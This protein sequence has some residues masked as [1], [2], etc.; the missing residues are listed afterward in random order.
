MSPFNPAPSKTTDDLQQA[1]T[2]FR[3]PLSAMAFAKA[4]WD[5]LCEYGPKSADYLPDG[6]SQYL[7]NGGYLPGLTSELS[8]KVS[9]EYLRNVTLPPS[10]PTYTVRSTPGSVFHVTLSV[11]E[12]EEVIQACFSMFGLALG[13][14]FLLVFL[15]SILAPLFQ[16][17]LDFANGFEQENG[18]NETST[19][20][21]DST[22]KKDPAPE[23]HAREKQLTDLQD[24]LRESYTNTVEY[25]AEIRRLDGIIAQSKDKN[26]VAF[27]RLIRLRDKKKRE[28]DAAR[29]NLAS[30]RSQI[31][32]LGAV[33][34]GLEYQNSVLI[35]KA[36]AYGEEKEDLAKENDRL[37]LSVDDLRASYDLLSEYNADIEARNEDLDQENKD[38]MRRNEEIETENVNWR[39]TL[40]ALKNDSEVERMK[41][42]ITTLQGLHALVINKNT[43]LENGLEYVQGISA[44]N[45]RRAT[46]ADN[47]LRNAEARIKDLEVQLDAHKDLASERD[48]LIT[49]ALDEI[50]EQRAEMTRLQKE[51]QSLMTASSAQAVTL[52]NQTLEIVALRVEISHQESTYIRLSKVID[53]RDEEIKALRGEMSHL[54]RTL[55][56]NATQSFKKDAEINVLKTA[57]DYMLTR[58]E[59]WAEKFNA[60]A[61]YKHT[62]EEAARHP[63]WES[64]GFE[65]LVVE[66]LGGDD[67]EDL[68][69]LEDLPDTT[70]RSDSADS[71]AITEEEQGLVATLVLTESEDAGKED[72]EEIYITEDEDVVIVDDAWCPE[73]P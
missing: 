5:C 67:F 15:L 7:I 48:E 1:T 69:D 28:L 6:M 46:Q 14:I 17:S 38:L 25:R 30:S 10:L 27:Q 50:N 4:S 66:Q 54:G 35:E 34:K 72:Y 45:A 40:Q 53:S 37:Q 23:D 29:A 8:R 16:L 47:N 24:L 56:D 42:Q 60:F 32:R 59:S 70:E 26:S 61:W 68:E 20:K 52:S 64:E 49:N 65:E 19:L 31:D 73:D 2:M 39:A 41:K 22:P 55:A 36:K 3:E 33:I 9:A 43:A 18:R 58:A 13:L 57:N 62:A 12:R 44:E 21:E 71:M 51:K 63:Q 11:A